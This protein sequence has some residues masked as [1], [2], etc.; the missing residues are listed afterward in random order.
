MENESP[1]IKV[2]KVWSPETQGFIK[3]QMKRVAV[4]ADAAD[5]SG[6]T[7]VGECPFYTATQHGG[8]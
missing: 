7:K 5:G 1:P 4:C 8:H 6:K 2:R 3:F